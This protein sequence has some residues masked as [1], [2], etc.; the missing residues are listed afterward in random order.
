MRSYPEI[1]QGS[2]EWHVIRHGKVGGSSSHQLHVK[3]DTLLNQLVSCRLE[4]F[5]EEEIG[6]QNAD[7]LRGQDM[8]P[9]ARQSLE[10]ATGLRFEQVGWIEREDCA[11]MGI[12]PDGITEDLKAGCE[13]KCP[14]RPIHIGYVR[15]G[16]LPL[17]YV[18]QV[19]QFFAVNEKLEA[20]W[21]A[22]Y[23]P[24]CRVPLF[25]VEVTRD[26]MVNSGTKAKP[27]MVQVGVYAMN[28]RV[29]GLQLEEDV[30]NEVKRVINNQF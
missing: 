11:I 25:K 30:E 17:D 18:D 7:M 20:V 12:S 3:S 29:L 22:S 23:R 14:S 10:A 2:L 28:K 15:A 21:F 6:Y 27:V 8:E 19:V 24:E 1:E 9:E 16:I 5:N 26:S 4:P 13:I